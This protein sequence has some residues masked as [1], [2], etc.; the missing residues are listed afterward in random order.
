MMNGGV[1]CMALLLLALILLVLLAAPVQLQADIAHAG[2]P[3]ARVQLTVAGFTHAW[4]LKLIRTPEGHQ[5]IT[6][7]RDGS[8]HALSQDQLRGGVADRLFGELRSCRMARRYLMRH[9][10][11][12]ALDAAL[13]IHSADAA[14]TAL[15]T[16]LVRGVALLL[17]PEMRQQV[18]LRVM[19]EFF[20]DRS[21]L[22]ARCIL[23]FRLGTI[24][25]TSG[26][27]LASIAAQRVHAA[28]RQH[29]Y[30]TSHR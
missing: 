18:R 2:Q 9:I 12:D 8:E 21:N 14:R 28:R 29:E 13:R 17:P 10:R 7:A 26:M 15:L 27:L 22:Q 20:R 19:P 16:G 24:F 30:G 11:L 4:R 23:R 25:I 3:L 5:L 6:A 1:S